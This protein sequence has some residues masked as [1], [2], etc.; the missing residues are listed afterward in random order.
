M[1]D[2]WRDVLVAAIGAL[3]G[4][5]V[6]IVVARLGFDYA[7]R[8]ET[9]RQGREDRLR[10]VI[11]PTGERSAHWNSVRNVNWHPQDALIYTDSTVEVVRLIKGIAPSR[12]VLR[13]LGGSVG[14]ATMSVE[15]LGLIG[16]SGSYLAFLIERQTP[17]EQG[18]EL[19]W[20]LEGYEGL[21][22]H[23]AGGG[24]RNE[25]TGGETTPEEIASLVR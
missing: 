9:R 17:T 2:N 20:T 4:L 16:G 3:G 13:Q 19:A 22:A 14:N 11:R 18:T 23:G 12:L 7:E 6:G 21:F 10:A 5:S 24:W 15:D 25:T 1:T 8:T